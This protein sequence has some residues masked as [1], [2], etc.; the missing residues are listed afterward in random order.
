MGVAVVVG[1]RV[2]VGVMVGVSEGV[3]VLEAVGVK[4]GVGERVGVPDTGCCAGPLEGP[5]RS[6][7]RTIRKPTTRMSIFFEFL[8]I[9]TGS[10]PK[11]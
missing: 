2:R 3:G 1:V 7:A 11:K 5:A 10:R 4:V 9:P 6:Q 8:N